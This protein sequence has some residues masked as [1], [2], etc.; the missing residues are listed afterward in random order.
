M[1][2]KLF[3]KT[4]T[5]ETRR[6]RVGRLILILLVLLLAFKGIL[7]SIMNQKGRDLKEELTDETLATLSDVE[8]DNPKNV[9]LI[10]AD[11]MGYGDISAFGSE[12]I[13]TPNLDQLAE[14]GTVLTN[15]YSPAPTCT[16]SR[17]GLLT[18]RYSVRTLAPVPFLYAESTTFK[19][20]NLMNIV[21][22]SYAYG[23]EEIAPDE[24]LLDE[25]LNGYD[26]ETALIGKWHLGSKEGQRPNDHGFDYFY[27]A[28]Y[29]NDI[30]PYEIY[31][32]EEV[33]MEAPVNQ[34]VLT[35]VFTEEAINFI[36]TNKEQPFF[37]Y[38]ASPFPHD[39]AHASD[40]FKGS[41][42]AGVFGDSVQELDWSIGEIINSL[43]EQGIADETLIIFT[44]DNGLWYEGSTGGYRG[45][46]ATAFSGGMKVPFI[47]YLPGVIEGGNTLNG[48]VSGIDLFPTIIELIGG[49]LPND[50]IIDGVSVLSYLEGDEKDSPRDELFI[51]NG[52]KLVN[53]ISDDYKYW[54]IGKDLTGM[55]LAPAGKAEFLFNL[56]TDASES[57]NI[58]MYNEDITASLKKK[59]NMMKQSLDDNLRG[60]ID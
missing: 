37:L 26:Y 11:D 12:L 30:E 27:G 52:K 17:A 13:D 16:P 44:S 51:F 1:I 15:Y 45:R 38:Y 34:D 60:W 6:F 42:D 3:F 29:S 58:A 22:D 28:L 48:L 19:F 8:L 2:K 10:V 55:T 5:N 43:E 7:M 25:L 41:S 49:E 9:V 36:E 32:N 46:K 18:G 21:M 33:V 40:D 24:I 31:Q 14:V 59:I 57:Y 35:T 53:M 39:P 47:T 50:R 54:P 23:M 4:Y 20:A 56:K